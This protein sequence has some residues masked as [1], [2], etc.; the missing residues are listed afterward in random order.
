VLKIDQAFVAGIER[1]DTEQ[2]IIATI[3]KLGKTLG[4]RI[5]A[6]GVENQQQA[7]FLQTAGCDQA[8]GYYFSKPVAP[9]EMAELMRQEQK[10]HQIEKVG[11]IVDGETKV[12]AVK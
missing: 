10:P 9:E 1:S 12:R 2:T 3:I 11:S 8:Q 7:D 4:M 5:V 6:E